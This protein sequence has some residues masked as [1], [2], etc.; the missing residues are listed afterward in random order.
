MVAQPPSAASA[1]EQKAAAATWK[2]PSWC[3]VATQDKNVPPAALHF[4]PCAGA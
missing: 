2:T 1:L 3:T 4:V